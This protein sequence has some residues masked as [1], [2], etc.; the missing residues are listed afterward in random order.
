LLD[1]DARLSALK[2]EIKEL[3]AAV[4]KEKPKIKTQEDA[5]EA[6][7]TLKNFETDQI[8]TVAYF[9]KGSESY[10][11]KPPRIEIDGFVETGTTTDAMEKAK[12]KKF[13]LPVLHAR[14]RK[15]QIA[16]S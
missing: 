9:A 6:V 16:E 3:E 15:Q 11:S 1:R 8:F 4:L 7:W 2:S 13:R 10:L 5:K 14:L 12:R